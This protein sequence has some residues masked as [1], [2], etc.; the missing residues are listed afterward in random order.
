MTEK[1]VKDVLLREQRKSYQ[2]KT[3]WKQ[4]LN[5]FKQ[6]NPTQMLLA[7]EGFERYI[8][9]AEKCGLR[10]DPAPFREII[11]DAFDNRQVWKE[12]NAEFIKKTGDESTKRFKQKLNIK[13]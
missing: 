13:S 1:N 9:A 2:H 6:L 7:I 4:V 3:I 11:E 5:K 10:L 12:S 8:N